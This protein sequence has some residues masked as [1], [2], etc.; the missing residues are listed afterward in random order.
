[1]PEGRIQFATCAT[2]ETIWTAQ[3]TAVHPN[4]AEALTG[5]WLCVDD[6]IATAHRYARFL[7]RNA[8][9]HRAAIRIDLDRGQLVF[10]SPAEPQEFLPD[11]KAPDVPYMAGVS[12]STTD[13][14]AARAC[15]AAAGVATLHED[16]HAVHVGPQDG[17]GSCLVLHDP[18]IAPPWSRRT[19]RSDR[20]G[21]RRCPN[22]EDGPLPSRPMWPGSTYRGGCQ[23]AACKARSWLP[24][25][26]G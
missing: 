17:L 20:G 23:V 11:P 3:P 13:V 12:V 5:L 19:N 15:L 8:H 25:P 18:A 16:D 9:H 26:A 24:G 10:T 4:A 21:S 14:R 22:T 2:P 6:R 1:M 7:N